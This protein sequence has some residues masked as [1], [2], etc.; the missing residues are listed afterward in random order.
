MVSVAIHLYTE[1]QL[2]NYKTVNKT[3]Y[4]SDGKGVPGMRK[5][6]GNTEASIRDHSN[7]WF[8][9]SVLFII[10]VRFLIWFE[11]FKHSPLHHTSAGSEIWA[12]CRR[13]PHNN[14]SV[15]A[16]LTIVPFWRNRGLA[17]I[18]LRGGP[19]HNV[20]STYDDHPSYH[21][22]FRHPS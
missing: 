15:C 1:A 3:R 19:E 18:F 17:R 2:W 13:S 8:H 4:N 5:S 14:N 16:A 9:V 10:M 11:L 21:H 20:N 12:S 7:V 6:Y 22:P